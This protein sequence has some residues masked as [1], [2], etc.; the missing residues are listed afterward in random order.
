[1]TKKGKGI[2]VGPYQEFPSSQLLYSR[3]GKTED[4]SAELV[5]TITFVQIEASKEFSLAVSPAHSHAP[6]PSFVDLDFPD[7]GLLLCMS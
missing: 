6:C 7:L 5:R 4:F 2:T 1:M 3:G